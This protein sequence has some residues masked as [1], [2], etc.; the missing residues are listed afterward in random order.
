MGD[1]YNVFISWSGAR[2]R[3]AAEYV[4]GWLPKVIQAAKPWM[5][6][7]DIDKG[8]RSLEEISRRL[9]GAKVGIA[10]LTPENLGNAWILYESGAL[11]K[12]IDDK[13]RLCTYLLG[14]LR[15]DQIAPPLG[16]FQ[17]TQPNKKETF[18]L[19]QT[20]N[21]AVSNSPL[22]AETLSSVFE[23]WWPDL[24]T[25]IKNLPSAE[26]PATPKRKTDEIVVEL[27]AYARANAENTEALQAQIKEGIEI[28][29]RAP[30]ATG[31]TNSLWFQPESYMG[32][33]ENL[34]TVLELIQKPQSVQYKM[35]PPVRS[36][37][38]EQ[39]TPSEQKPPAVPQKKPDSN[40]E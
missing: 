14:G 25:A 20:V 38:V 22:S 11:T 12:T 10:C 9:Q 4:R 6:E 39:S 37:R 28:L 15:P 33:P 32:V 16:M 40:G 23:K 7:S 8:A 17:H 24:E 31:V 13:T 3:F 36:P 2:S 35:G 18:R 30:F 1:E 27:L 5:S 34:R 19:M 21:Q 26:A 29:R